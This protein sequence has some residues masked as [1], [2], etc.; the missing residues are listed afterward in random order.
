M[1][2][3]PHASPIAAAVPN[4]GAWVTLYLPD[5]SKVRLTA[6]ALRE[7]LG[8]LQDALQ[9]LDTAATGKDGIVFLCVAHTRKLTLLVRRAAR[10]ALWPGLGSLCLAIVLLLP[11]AWAVMSAPLVALLATGTSRHILPLVVITGLCALIAA[12]AGARHLLVGEGRLLRPGR[13]ELHAV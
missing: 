2:P 8:N 4:Q 7:S 13:P 5:G 1:N 11:L 6:Q 12:A 3:A 10:G 9:L